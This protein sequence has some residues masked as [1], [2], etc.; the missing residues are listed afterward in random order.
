MNNRKLTNIFWMTEQMTFRT[1]HAFSCQLGS[2]LHHTNT[3]HHHHHHQQQQQQQEKFHQMLNTQHDSSM[4][5][6]SVNIT[7]W[8]PP[9]TQAPSL[10]YL[11]TPMSFAFKARPM[12]HSIY[13]LLS[14]LVR[15]LSRESNTSHRPRPLN[16]QLNC[17]DLDLHP[18]DLLSH[19]HL[20]AKHARQKGF[21]PYVFPNF[22]K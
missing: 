3:H 2:F 11:M 1:R 6:W 19:A 20:T 21:L 8:E 14:S 15:V 18:A 9:V 16:C 17:D 22:L 7:S 5:L 10:T 13:H 12:I 4:Q